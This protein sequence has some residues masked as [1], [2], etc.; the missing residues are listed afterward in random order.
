[1]AER[2]QLSARVRRDTWAAVAHTLPAVASVSLALAVLAGLDGIVFGTLSPLHGLVWA[3]LS[4]GCALY[5]C[6]GSGQGSERLLGQVAIAVSIVALSAA[7]VDFV[8]F[9]PCGFSCLNR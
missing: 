8:A 2:D 7:L 9:S 3:A 5:A 4:F 6:F 1:V